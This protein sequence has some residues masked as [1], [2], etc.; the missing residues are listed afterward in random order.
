[1]LFLAGLADDMDDGAEQIDQVLSS[2][3]AAEVFGRMVAAL[4]GPVDFVERYPDR[5]PSCPV[6]V[7]VPAPQAGFVT[8]VD[9]RTLGEVVVRLGG[10]RALASDRINPAVGLSNLAIVGEEM[11]L[12]EPL[13]LIHA[14]TI[15]DAHAARDAILRA[16]TLGADMPEEPALIHDRIGPEVTP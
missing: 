13:A 9:A 12:D 1:M 10:G 4:G 11:A 3:R 6:M 14:A 15:E 8:R 7:P 5:L 2:G 16:Y